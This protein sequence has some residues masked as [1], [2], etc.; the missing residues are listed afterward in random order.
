[1]RQLR[2][3]RKRVPVQLDAARERRLERVRAR[4]VAREQAAQRIGAK[5]GTVRLVAP[6]CREDRARLGAGLAVRAVLEREHE[7]LEEAPVVVGARQLR[8]AGHK[9]VE[10]PR[11]FARVGG[12]PERERRDAVERRIDLGSALGR[13]VLP[14]RARID[15]VVRRRQRGEAHEIE[16]REDLGIVREVPDPGRMRVRHVRTPRARAL[17]PPRSSHRRRRR[18]VR[19]S[20]PAAGGTVASVP[21]THSHPGSARRPS[22]PS[23]R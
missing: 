23:A 15:R 7:R 8:E 13:Q 14:E 16:R 20:A 1:V 12:A 11:L 5:R 9:A 4:A 21:R 3:A 10:E 19:T 17:R 22:V 6:R 2:K 18:G